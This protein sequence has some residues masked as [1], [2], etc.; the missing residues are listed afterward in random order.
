MLSSLQSIRYR[1]KALRQGHPRG[2][3][4]LPSD[5]SVSGSRADALDDTSLSYWDPVSLD[6]LLDLTV[7][8]QAS[9]SSWLCSSVESGR[10]VEATLY[11]VNTI[12][13]VLYNFCVS[14]CAWP[15]L[16]NQ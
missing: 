11:R 4:A 3:L 7:L 8:L 9:T 12:K 6:T 13:I 15:F 16:K 10:I 2:L 14:Y 1:R 5:G